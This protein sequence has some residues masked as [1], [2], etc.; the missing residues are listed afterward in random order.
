M[1]YTQFNVI[2]YLSSPEKLY[3]IMNYKIYKFVLDHT[4]TKYQKT[5]V[6]L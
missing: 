6:Y 4:L 2:D 1:L 5:L 3:H